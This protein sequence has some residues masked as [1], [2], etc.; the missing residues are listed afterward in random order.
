MPEDGADEIDEVAEWLCLRYSMLEPGAEDSDVDDEE[1]PVAALGGIMGR[2]GT[3]EW[4]CPL[5][6][7]L[8]E[9]IRDPL[10]REEEFELAAAA[11]AAAAAA[12]TAAECWWLAGTVGRAEA[13][14]FE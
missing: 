6:L 12:E 3:W 9:G 7:C 10:E 8:D 13:R 5:L 2:K 4:P 14:A 11:A 1:G